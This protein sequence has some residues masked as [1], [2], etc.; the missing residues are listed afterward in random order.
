MASLRRFPT[1]PYW[2]A[3]FCGPDGRRRQASTKQTNRKAAQR[4]AYQFEAGLVLAKPELNYERQHRRLALLKE[5]LDQCSNS[6]RLSKRFWEI[7]RGIGCMNCDCGFCKWPAILEFH[8]IDR[9]R[10]N[11]SLDN[12]SVLCPNCHKAHH[13]KVAKIVI[14]SL[15]QLM[16]EHGLTIAQTAEAK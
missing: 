4:I 3:C 11:D 15:A 10:A 8:H 6:D 14:K 16:Q 5:E 9:N 7:V 12:L 2:F 1:S 13:R